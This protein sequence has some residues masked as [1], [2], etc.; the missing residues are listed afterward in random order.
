MPKGDSTEGLPFALLRRQ[1]LPRD[2]HPAESV[3]LFPTYRERGN[4][5]LAESVAHRL[6][7]HGG[8]GVEDANSGLKGSMPGPALRETEFRDGGK[9]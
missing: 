1:P 2:P 8:G 9:A 4:A 7:H 3:S 5:S 6:T